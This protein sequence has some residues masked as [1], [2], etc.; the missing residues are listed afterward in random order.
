MHSVDAHARKF[1]IMKCLLSCTSVTTPEDTGE[2]LR[3]NLRTLISEDFKYESGS[4]EI[5]LQ[6]GRLPT[7]SGELTGLYTFLSHQ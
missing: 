2:F 4:R 7:I 5:T 1:V 6:I 3:L